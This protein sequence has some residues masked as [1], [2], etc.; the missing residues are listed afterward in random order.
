MGTS[1]GK[2]P[3]RPKPYEDELLSS[4][5]TRLALGHGLKVPAFLSIVGMQADLLTFDWGPEERVLRFL[6]EKTDVDPAHL[7][8][9]KLNFELG[10]EDFLYRNAV[11][12]AVQYCPMCLAETAYFR[13][14]WR[15]SFVR[16][17][18]PHSAVLADRCSACGVAVRFEELDPAFGKISVCR[19][20][21][22]DLASDQPRQVDSE[23][24]RRVSALQER[25]LTSIREDD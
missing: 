21:L 17:C 18:Q 9:L 25:L 7:S 24:A 22:H 3:F 12:P 19:N 14:S 6:A 10:T 13:R 20:C 1:A 16:I 2:W 4:W 15:V 11:A 5:L 23:I 8:D